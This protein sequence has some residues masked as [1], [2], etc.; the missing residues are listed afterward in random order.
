M[1]TAGNATEITSMLRVVQELIDLNK[2]S[3]VVATTQL[4][5][6]LLHASL[7]SN[8]NENPN[9]LPPQNLWR[10]N[11]GKNSSKPQ[12]RDPNAPSQ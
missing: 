6:L 2:I 9:T 10:H 3:L 1:T 5:E 12:S 4:R 7:E 8:M 11:G